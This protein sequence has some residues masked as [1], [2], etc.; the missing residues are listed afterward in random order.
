MTHEGQSI[1]L[2][3]NRHHHKLVKM[4][5]LDFRD[6]RLC[7][8]PG[9]NLKKLGIL[10]NCY[11]KKDNVVWTEYVSQW[12]VYKPKVNTNDEVMEHCLTDAMLT[13]EILVTTMSRRQ[14]IYYVLE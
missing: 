5:N 2:V 11:H 12:G 13:M 10:N 7:G 8:S 1:P 9:I 4:Y 14:D 3:G 6:W